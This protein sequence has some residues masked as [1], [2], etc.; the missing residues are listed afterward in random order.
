MPGQLN[1]TEVIDQLFRSEDL[2]QIF[3]D[4][5]TLCQANWA[6][7]KDLFQIEHHDDAYW[8]KTKILRQIAGKNH[9]IFK[10]RDAVAFGDD[11]ALV[12]AFA[13]LTALAKQ[14]EK[15][16]GTKLSR[17][18]SPFSNSAGELY[19]LALDKPGRIVKRISSNKLP[20]RMD[21]L[22][23]S[24][25]SYH[26][27]LLVTPV[28]L[29]T[30][31]RLELELTRISMNEG[32]ENLLA[33]RLKKGQFCIA[34]SPLSYKAE[35][36]IEPHY[37]QSYLRDKFH[38][39]S[40]GPP[41]EQLA[42]IQAALEDASAKGVSILVLPELRMPPALLEE[43]KQFLRWQSLVDEERGLLMVVAGSWHV[44]DREGHRANRCVVLDYY[45]NELW[46]HDKLLEF[47]ITAGN[48]KE[49]PQAYQQMGIREGGATEAIHCGKRLEFYD[50]LVGRLAVAICVGFFSQEVEP[51]LWASGANV[52]F[53]PSM[54]PST[55]DLEA[56]ANALVRSQNAL[57]FVANCGHVGPNAR[58]FY[59]LP[60]KNAKPRRLRQG[61]RMLLF[62]MSELT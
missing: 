50:S 1:P 52:F 26:A 36:K 18:T 23:H 3:L 15:R 31:D 2:I 25:R 32:L 20:R 30:P 8:S 45:G 46:R 44:A 7:A 54:T 29:V 4:T 59:Q 9:P 5:Y 49:S 53:V 19:W 33:W 62:D 42:A 17:Y 27:P 39:S 11:H 24:F 55:T 34:V 16:H 12:R 6:N 48:V 61:R 47:V 37:R 43:T 60:I 21:Q 40:V 56:R 22:I 58:S 13:L 35:I 51:L 10:L 38:V 57:T 41:A 14:I 28:R